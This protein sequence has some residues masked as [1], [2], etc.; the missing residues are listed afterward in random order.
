MAAQQTQQRQPSQPANFNRNAVPRGF[1]KPRDGAGNLLQGKALYAW[2]LGA[3]AS[4]QT[5]RNTSYVKAK[6]IGYY[7]PSYVKQGEQK[8]TTEPIVPV[9]E[10]VYYTSIE[11]FKDRLQDA[12]IQFN[13]VD[14]KAVLPQ[15]L[16]G[17][18]QIWWSSEVT[19]ADKI[20]MQSDDDNLTLIREKLTD[21][22]KANP[23][24]S[25]DNF[26]LERYT[27][28][29]CQS[30]TMSSFLN[31]KLIQAKEAHIQDDMILIEIYK[32]YNPSFI[33]TITPPDRTTPVS[34]FRTEIAMKE[35]QIIACHKGRANPRPDPCFGNRV[36][37]GQRE[38]ASRAPVPNTQ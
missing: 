36:P 19:D 7:N 27:T 26:K 33:V 1:S 2:A 17:N 13:P 29:T 25:L 4:V 34:Q 28:A 3:L 32:L 5:N 15:C 23:Y 10:S 24:T 11:A 30:Q 9:G 21:R 18:A 31:K 14:I 35:H 16:R 22:F 20:A 12:C 8:P 37:Q 38:Y 6:D